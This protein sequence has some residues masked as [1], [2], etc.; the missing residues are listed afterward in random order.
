MPRCTIV[1]RLHFNAA[2]RLHNPAR[3]ADWNAETFGP[4]NNPNYHGHNYE[5]EVMVE[6][7]IDPETGYV[8]DV[9]ILKQIVEAE[10]IRHLDHRNLNLDV[11]WFS[12]RLPS[13]EN[14]AVFIWE[15]LA[16]RIPRG[17]LKRVRLWETPRN[18]VDYE[19][20]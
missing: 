8:L 18:W 9:G 6:G 5:L 15:H 20:E 7:E 19:G 11:A 4:C 12:S 2:H 3:S 16:G 17:R 14:I 1:R 10:V 13:A